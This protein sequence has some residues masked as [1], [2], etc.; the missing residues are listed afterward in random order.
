[1]PYT[2]L[3]KT[4]SVMLFY[5]LACAECYRKIYGGV[6]FSQQVLEPLANSTETCTIGSID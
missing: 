6:V 4:G 2:L 3:T 5:T 1:M